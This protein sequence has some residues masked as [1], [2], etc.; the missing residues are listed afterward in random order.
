MF[1]VR[2]RVAEIQVAKTAEKVGEIFL[3][4][5]FVMEND[6]LW[7]SVKTEVDVSTC[8][9]SHFAFISLVKIINWVFQS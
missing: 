1:L 8:M 5:S 3:I 7:F 6:H 2:L 4:G 9:K